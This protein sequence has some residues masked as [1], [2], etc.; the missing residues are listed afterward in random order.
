MDLGPEPGGQSFRGRYKVNQ[1][2]LGFGFQVQDNLHQ[3]FDWFFMGSATADPSI[4]GVAL[5]G[6]GLT[7]PFPLVNVRL[8]P[9]VGLHTY[10]NRT[11]DSTH[12]YRPPFMFSDGYM[13]TIIY[14][15]EKK[16]PT[17]GPM[18]VLSVSMWP[19]ANE[20]RKWTPY[21]QYQT[22]WMGMSAND[23]DNYVPRGILNLRGHT[24]AAGLDYTVGK[25]FT[26]NTRIARESQGNMFGSAT[27]HRIESGFGVRLPT[28]RL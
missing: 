15:Q 1:P 4:R 10:T 18:R 14:H 26:V 2:A 7:L 28:S 21:L 16:R 24:F 22:H 27:N 12:I 13:D 3:L 19:P 9:A 8:S 6:A 23:S 11:V 5:V 20:H 25:T 17:F